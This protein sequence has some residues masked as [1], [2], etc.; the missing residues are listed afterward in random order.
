MRDGA[1][2]G[3]NFSDPWGTPSTNPEVT[4]CPVDPDVEQCASA[5]D[6]CSMAA[7]SEANVGG[8]C[9]GLVCDLDRLGGFRCREAH[10]SDEDD[11]FACRR[12]AAARSRSPLNVST[13]VVTSQGISSTFRRDVA[14]LNLEAAHLASLQAA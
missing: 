13:D 1:F 12:A 6:P 10:G 7:L 3:C 14:I 5:G 11:L 8:C 9:D 4:A 2:C